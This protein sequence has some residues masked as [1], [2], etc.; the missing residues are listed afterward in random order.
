MSG[1]ACAKMTKMPIREDIKE[2]QEN[3]YGADI[4]Y[5]KGR[6]R[7]KC[8]PDPDERVWGV[9]EKWI[10]QFDNIIKHPGGRAKGCKCEIH[11]PG[12]LLCDHSPTP[13]ELAVPTNFY[14]SNILDLGTVDSTQ[15]SWMSN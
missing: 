14:P 12:K 6:A 9:D 4:P 13:P 2:R 8:P 15:A 1:R 11:S 3:G 10:L 7:V 5:S